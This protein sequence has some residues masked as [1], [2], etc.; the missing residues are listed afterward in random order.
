MSCE[1]LSRRSRFSEHKA[2]SEAIYDA[3]SVKY[4]LIRIY[5]LASRIAILQNK[6]IA[7]F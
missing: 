7:R 5:L 1:R 6:L 4:F 2:A 3:G